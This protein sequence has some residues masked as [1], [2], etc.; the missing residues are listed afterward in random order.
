MMKITED[1][2]KE[3][4][5]ALRAVERARSALVNFVVKEKL[6]ELEKETKPKKKQPTTPTVKTIASGVEKVKKPRKPKVK[7]DVDVKEE[8]HSDL[9]D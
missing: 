5:N 7:K 1:G 3:L 4:T 9:Y 2:A 6:V 8:C